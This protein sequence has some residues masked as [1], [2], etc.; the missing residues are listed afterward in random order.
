MKHKQE[1]KKFIEDYFH[2]YFTERNFHKVKTFFSED[3]TGIGT[4][5]DELGITTEKMIGLYQ[6]DIEQ[7]PDPIQYN[8]LKIHIGAVSSRF[9]IVH[10]TFDLLT[11]TSE[12]TIS[13]PSLRIS[14]A[15][16]KVDHSWKIV[17]KHISVPFEEQEESESYPIQKLTEKNIQLEKMVEKR[18]SELKIVNSQLQKSNAAKDKFFSIIA[19]DLRSP[20][21]SIL[22][23][24]ELLMNDYDNMDSKAHKTIIKSMNQSSKKVFNLINNLL[25]W[26]RSQLEIIQ[27]KPLVH[28]IHNIA[29][30]SITILEDMARGKNISIENKIKKSEKVFCDQFMVSTIFR[31]LISNAIKFTPANGVI[32]ITADSETSE[33]NGFIKVCVND[34]GIGIDPDLIPNLFTLVGNIS[35]QG[36]NE[37][38]GTG[39]GLIICKE[40]I[41]NHGT[42][43]W[44]ESSKGK[45]S[46]IC[47]ILKMQ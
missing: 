34:T 7:M 19:H 4:G 45:G 24:A 28:D 29:E 10:C 47:F 26:S 21:N 42:K 5:L 3:F 22:G 40:F 17:L 38:T 11:E 20:F 33:S 25:D 31:N 46:K 6:R 18:T 12:G 44:A 36:T 8:N 23:F 37:E 41:D 14:L 15:L 1:I 39:L 2:V 30:E 27:F 32:T 16:S 35:T 43:I 13:I 9:S